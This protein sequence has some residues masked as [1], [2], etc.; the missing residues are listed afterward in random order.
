MTE[1]VDKKPGFEKKITPEI[2]LQLRVR[3]REIP[4]TNHYARAKKLAPEF[5]LLS[6]R[7]LIDYSRLMVNVCDEVFQMHLDG[8]LSL[9]ALS[10]FGVW[11]NKTQIYMANEYIEKKLTPSVLRIVKQLK[12]EHDISFAEAI[13]RATGEIPMDKPRKEE[14]RNLDQILTEIA[15]KG[16]RWRALVDMAIE[17]VGDQEAAAGVHMALFE[18]VSVLRELIGNQYDMVNGRFNRY[19]AAIKKRLTRDAA[20]EPEV[21][22]DAADGDAAPAAEGKVIDAEVKIVEKKE[23]E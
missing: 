17:M 9:T 3:M 16:A 21:I 10:E 22:K 14:R 13:G 19:M 6:E 8:K 23:D 2:V 7:T 4:E 12:R 5:P 1:N 20:P 18:K 11:D 15:D